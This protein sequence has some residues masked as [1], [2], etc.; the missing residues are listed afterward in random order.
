MK[1]LLISALT[2]VAL[3]SFGSVNAHE[4]HNHENM[5]EMKKDEKSIDLI[6]NVTH[7]ES[8]KC[9]MAFNFAKVAKMR[10]H[11]VVVWLNSDAVKLADANGKNKEVVKKLIDEGIKVYVCPVCSKR[12][13]VKKLV[14]G[15]E[16]SNPDIIFGILTK[17]DTKVVS[18]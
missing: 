17:E 10:G 15:A 16:F 11:N 12:F 14:E 9:L 4:C 18:W 8:G 5:G 13:G 1:K 7:S 3:I 6:V 2:A